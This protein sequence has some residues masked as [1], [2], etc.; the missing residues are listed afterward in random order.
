LNEGFFSRCLILVE[1]E[2]E[3]MAFPELLSEFGIDCDSMGISII[4]V[5]GKNQIPKYWRLYSQFQ[6]PIIVVFDDDNSENSNKNLAVCFGVDPDEIPVQDVNYFKTMTSAS[7]PN[8][9]IIIMKKDFETAFK[10]EL[11]QL[12]VGLYDQL[13]A[14]A[15]ELIM[16]LRN[17]QKGTVEGTSFV[18]SN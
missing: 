9:E 6:I 7:L 2:T 12:E 18:M 15:K 5:N 16:P 17:Q 1:G 13:E 14:K 8:T 3:E 11:E 10:H 4:G